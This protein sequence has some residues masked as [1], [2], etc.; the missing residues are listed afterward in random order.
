MLVQ[1]TDKRA[2]MCTW[3][4][5]TVPLWD[6]LKNRRLIQLKNTYT[7]PLSEQDRVD[8]PFLQKPNLRKACEW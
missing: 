8:H 3:G 5:S 4:R 7:N 6:F 1:F 2:E